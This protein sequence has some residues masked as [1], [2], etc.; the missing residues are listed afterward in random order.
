VAERGPGGE[1]AA[2]PPAVSAPAFWE[3]LYR[4]GEAGWDI[5]QAAPAFVRWLASDGAPR[6]RQRVAV[7]GAGEGHDALAFARAGHAVTA[8]DFADSAIARARDRAA[9]AGVAV[10]L[11]QADV[12][13]LPPERHAAFDLVVED[14]FFTAIDPAR[15]RQ[16]AEVVRALLAPG[17]AL[18]GLFLVGPR[19]DGPPFPTSER[20]VLSLFR[21]DFVAERREQTARRPSPDDQPEWLFLVLRRRA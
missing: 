15:R 20:E 1:S 13:A 3:E 18:V 4:R 10:E 9:D 12:F 19:Q 14:A 8:F 16:Y 6:G 2:E 7:L 21:P 11:V 5:G 17:G